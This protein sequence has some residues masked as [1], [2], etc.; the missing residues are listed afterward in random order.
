[1]P[2]RRRA[3]TLSRVIEVVCAVIVDGGRVMLCRRA[4]GFH[5]AGHWEFPG[6]KIEAGE[7]PE[8]ALRRE[9]MEELDCEVAVGEALVPVVHSYADLTIRLRPFYCAIVAR[10]PRPLEHEEI[11]W[12]DAEGLRTTGLAG[13]DREVARQVSLV[14]STR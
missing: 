3:P 4:E 9:I 14:K 7:S 11:L 12:F 10:V 2:P 6:G 5:L 8:D 1:M 13:A